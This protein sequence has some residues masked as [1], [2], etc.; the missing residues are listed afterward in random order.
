MS[1]DTTQASPRTRLAGKR[2]PSTSGRTRSITI[3]AS[4]L[5]PTAREARRGVRVGADMSCYGGKM[6]AATRIQPAGPVKQVPVRA[7]E[8]AHTVLRAGEHGAVW[9][10][11]TAKTTEFRIHSTE[12]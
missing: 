4:P 3:G 10:L 1:A 7:R 8:H 12:F 11:V 2:P 9:Y 5:D 6:G